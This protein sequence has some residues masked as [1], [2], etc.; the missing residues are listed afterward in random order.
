MSSIPNILSFLRLI[1][2]PLV[3]PL[4]SKDVVAGLSLFTLLAITDGVDGYLARR[5]KWESTTGKFLDPLADKLLLFCG[6]LS[7]S[8]MTADK[9]PPYLFYLLLV[10]DIYLVVGTYL[11]KPKGFIPQPTLFGKIA[12]FSTIM[13][14]V[15]AYLLNVWELALLSFLTKLFYLIAIASI[16]ISWF[17]YTAKAVSFIGDERN[18]TR[19][20]DSP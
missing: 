18:N 6:L 9:I 10:R 7:V 20:V 16:L 17:Q 2:S 14:V 4:S 11:L 19:G 13:V 12:T 5:F 15:L 8:F 3:I 1:L